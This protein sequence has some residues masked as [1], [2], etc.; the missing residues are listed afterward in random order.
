M[1]WVTLHK[2]IYTLGVCN[3]VYILNASKSI[4][5]KLEKQEII[6]PPYSFPFL[7][8]CQIYSFPIYLNL[9]FGGT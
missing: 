8:F 3:N 1:I 2:Y 5:P 9:L 7:G 6:L 4:G